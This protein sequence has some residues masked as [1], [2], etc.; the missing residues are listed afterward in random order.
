MTARAVNGKGSQWDIRK[1]HSP[2]FDEIFR[3]VS[4]PDAT[5]RD[6]NEPQ[7]RELVIE[8][9]PPGTDRGGREGWTTKRK[10]SDPVTDRTV[11]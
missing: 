6:S 5:D 3:T 2:D 4:F 7:A 10:P 11:Q 8:L 1:F 9:L